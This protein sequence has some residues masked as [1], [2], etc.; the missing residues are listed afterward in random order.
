MERKLAAILCADVYGY[1]RLMGEDEEA[2]LRTLTSH[3]KLI[4]SQIEQHHGRFVNSAGDSV[5]A[6]FA[7]VVEA[8]NCAVE[9]QT[10]LKEQNASLAPERRME[11]RIGVNLGDVMVAGAQIYGDGVNVAARLESLAEPGG[12]CISGTAYDHVRDKLALA[13]EDAGE[14]AV[15]NIARPVHVWR[16]LL[17]GATATPRATRQIRRRYWRVGGLS[18]AGLAIVIGTIVLVQHLSLKPQTTHASIPSQ[19]KPALPLPNIPSIAVLPFANLS[20]DP[21]QDYFSDGI[22]DQLINNLS[23]LPGLFVIARNSSF[24]YKGKP[25]KESQIAKELGVKYVLE[26]SAR[27]AADHV[28][29]GV[30]LVDASSGTEMWTDHYNR[31]LTDIFAVQDEIVGKVVTTL[32]LILKLQEMRAPYGVRPGSD[33]LEAY[34]DFLR[35]SEYFWRFTKDDNERG[36]QWVEMAIQLDPKFADA[37][38]LAG[39]SYWQDALFRWSKNP[40]GDLKHSSELAH[41]ALAL[42]DSNSSALALM[43]QIDWM[44]RQFARAVAEGERAVAINPN[45]PN[46]YEALSDALINSDKFEEAAGAAKTAMRLDPAHQDLYAFFVG[47]PY[48]FMGRYEDAIALL[49]RHIAVF[50]DN[51]WAHAMLAMAYVELGRVQDARAQASEVMRINPQFALP[52]PEKETNEDIAVNKHFQNDMRKAGLK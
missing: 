31:P 7:S 16:V 34:D 2:T 4:D 28:R 40:G 27:K 32:G 29:I 33:N 37:Y 45:D 19:E 13:Y 23:Q 48:V 9:I 39:W 44:Q 52:P 35:A 21:Q 15:K 11:F 1:S 30:E 50:P 49:K 20:G 47:S 17:D 10:G 24:V 26:G 43:S 14:Q 46:C 42:D 8:V 3:R 18:L 38:A 51:L 12:I 36:R 6:E 25:T 22:S 41:N 5:L